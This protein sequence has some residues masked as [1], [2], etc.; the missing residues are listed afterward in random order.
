ML[1]QFK[2]R[3]I[4][5]MLKFDTYIAS[6]VLY[7]SLWTLIYMY[8]V[9]KDL[10]QD[11]DRDSVFTGGVL[12]RTHVFLF[13]WPRFDSHFAVLSGWIRFDIQFSVLYK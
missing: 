10:S 11:Y 1:R 3:E 5:K 7:V 6:I 13:R 8:S 4:T 12:V 2:L 9:C